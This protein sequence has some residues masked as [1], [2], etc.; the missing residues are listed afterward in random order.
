MQARQKKEREAKKKEEKKEEL[1]A[2]TRSH[3]KSSS[4]YQ[5]THHM[6]VESSC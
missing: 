1:A 5:C 4:V 2:L 6:A 3:S